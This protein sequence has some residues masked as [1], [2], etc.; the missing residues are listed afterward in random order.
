MDLHGFTRIYAENY[1][2]KLSNALGFEKTQENPYFYVLSPLHSHKPFPEN[3]NIIN[4]VYYK[5]DRRF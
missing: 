5:L 2:L 4:P 1:F 3:H